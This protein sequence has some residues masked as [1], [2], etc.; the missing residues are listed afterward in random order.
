MS[1][2]A[3]ELHPETPLSEFGQ[4]HETRINA[5]RLAGYAFLILFLELA[6]IRYVSAYVRVFGFYLNMV[7]IATFL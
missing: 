2:Q 1:L 5:M 7:L 3:N 4:P 6:L